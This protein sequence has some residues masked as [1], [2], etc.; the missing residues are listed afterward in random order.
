MNTEECKV[1]ENITDRP[2]WDDAPAWANYLTK[3]ANNYWQWHEDY[4]TTS[5]HCIT[6]KKRKQTA[7][8][9]IHKGYYAETKQGQALYFD[10]GTMNFYKSRT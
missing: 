7:A 3:D 10:Y 4:P 5:D 9:C 2:S 6:S 8:E 1:L